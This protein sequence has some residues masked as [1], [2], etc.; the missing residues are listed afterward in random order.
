MRILFWTRNARSMVIERL[1][2]LLPDEYGNNTEA[3]QSILDELAKN[4]IKANHKHL[5]IRKRII[6]FFSDERHSRED[7]IATV[8]NICLDTMQFNEFTKNHENIMSGLTEALQTV[9]RQEALWLD[10]RNK[11]NEAREIKEEQLQKL[12]TETREFQS[13]YRELKRNR[14]YVEI[15]GSRTNH[16]VWIEVINTAPILN[17]DFKRINDKRNLFKKHCELG[18]E[19]EFFINAIDNSEGGSGLGYATIDSHL[20]E[21][22]LDPHKALTLVSV[23]N[24]NVMVNLDLRKLPASNK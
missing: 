19:C 24:T 4:A 5:I 8:D 7:V 14:V 21:M 12:K 1:N 2:K 6:D 20:A 17:S 23:H 11:R 22:G 15:R 3:I 9:L 16:M 13:L 10:F 18:T